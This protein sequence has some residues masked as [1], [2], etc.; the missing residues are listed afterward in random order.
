MATYTDI[1]L[2]FTPTLT[3]DVGKITDFN[4]IKNT[5]ENNLLINNRIA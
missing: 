1:D 2:S 4:S 5:L 3:N